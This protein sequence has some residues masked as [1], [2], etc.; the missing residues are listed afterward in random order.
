MKKILVPGTFDIL[1]YGH[2]RFLKECA[3]LG[4][5]TVALATDKHAHPKRK[6]IMN[7]DERKES[8]LH[9]AYVAMVTAKDS[10]PLRPIILMTKADVVCYG[11]DWDR[12]QWMQLNGL[13]ESTFGAKFIE[14]NNPQVISTTMLIARA[15]H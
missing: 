14:I 5:V 9:L 1:H 4:L 7:Y 2:M 15:S 13:K 3:K 10:I 6:P 11:S 8:L 12:E